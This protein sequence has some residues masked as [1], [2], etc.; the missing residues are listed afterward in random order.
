MVLTKD[1]WSKQWTDDYLDLYNLAGA[2]GDAAWQAEIATALRRQ[3]SAYDDNIKEWTKEQLWMQFNTINYKMMELFTL[4][5]QS[6][7]TEEETAIRDLI[8]QLKLQRMDLAKQ[9]K[10]IC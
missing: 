6:S 1:Q 2:M 3:E 8:W 4:M 9:I 7:S 10:E 5:R